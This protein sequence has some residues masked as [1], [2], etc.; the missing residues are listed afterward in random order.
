MTE[1]EKEKERQRDLERKWRKMVQNGAGAS[2]VSTLQAMGKAIARV[3]RA[4][5]VSDTTKKVVISK[6]YEKYCPLPQPDITSRSTSQDKYALVVKFYQCD[7][8]SRQ[9]PGRKDYRRTEDRGGSG[10]LCRNG[11]QKR[12]IM[13]F[14]NS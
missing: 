9:A 7:D 3:G 6:L 1:K 10:S 12:P 11:S 13:I 8:I 5:P 4:F 14:S 2:N